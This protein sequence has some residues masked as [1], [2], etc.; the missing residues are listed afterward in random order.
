MTGKRYITADNSRYLPGYCINNVIAGVKLNLKQILLDLNFEIDNL[1]DVT[2]SEHSIL[3]SPR[4][5]LYS[6]TF[7]SI[8]KIKLL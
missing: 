2:L 5:G 4:P 6:E 3:P 7:N 1:F 8:F